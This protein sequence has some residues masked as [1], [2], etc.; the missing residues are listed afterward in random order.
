MRGLSRCKTAP[1]CARSALFFLLLAAC[2]PTLDETTC[3]FELQA[4]HRPGETYRC[5]YVDVPGGAGQVRVAVLALKGGNASGNSPV[6]YLSGGPSQSWANLGVS[7]IPGDALVQSRRDI[8]FIEQ[9]GTG[10]SEPL[11]ACED[12]DN[13]KDCHDRF[14]KRRIDTRTFNTLAMADDVDAVRKALGYDRVL[15][16]ATSYGTTWARAVLARHPKIVERALLDSAT[17][18]TVPALSSFASGVDS[19]FSVLFSACEADSA[20]SAYVP[21]IEQTML[22]AMAALRASPLKN[23]AGEPVFDEPSFFFTAYA[24]LSAAPQDVP[25][26]IRLVA[27]ATASGT[28]PSGVEETADAVEPKRRVREGLGQYFSVFCG[29]NEGVSAQDVAAD[30]ARVR[31]AFA[32][33]LAGVSGSL[34][35]ICSVWPHADA[36]F[37]TTLSP[38]PVLILSGAFDPRTPPS[39]AADAAD[40]LGAELVLVPYASHSVQGIDECVFSIAQG[41]LSVGKVD[42]ACLTET[43]IVFTTDQTA[44][45]PRTFTFKRR[46]TPA[47]ILRLA[48]RR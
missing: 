47:E 10:L 5:G 34:Q 29:D 32:E 14:A 35:A 24:L 45:E 7:A 46:Y 37:V 2:A 21:H 18:A 25:F 42:Q 3:P 48:S 26:F 19:A 28:L 12:N 20:C 15:I 8:V 41:F 23:A 4:T 6:L 39:H 44:R 22:D 36:R 31:P 11:L 1:M 9:R 16:A 38:A 27:D 30:I 13:I 33:M 40:A 17:A 43:R